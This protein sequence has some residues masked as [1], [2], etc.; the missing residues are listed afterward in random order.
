[1]KK[2]EGHFKRFQYN[3]AGHFLLTD[4]L[5]ETMKRTAR[6]S[7]QEGRIVNVSSEGHRF[8]YRE[9]IRFEKI[10]DESGYHFAS[11]F[12]E[13]CPSMLLNDSEHRHKCE[14]IQMLYNAYGLAAVFYV[15]LNF[16]LLCLLIYSYISLCAYGQSKLANI[17]H[18]SELS[19]RLK[20]IRI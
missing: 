13:N 12:F 9:G 11:T 6:E 7:N 1:M 19:R 20:V 10:N 15:F 4:L 2:I 8:A 17:L 14:Q 5:L 3:F 18:S 16:A